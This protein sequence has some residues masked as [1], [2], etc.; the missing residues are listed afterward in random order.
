MAV[1]VLGI[2]SSPRRDGNSD[3]LLKEVL[4]GAEGAGAQVEY[5]SLRGVQMSPCVE[6]NACYETGR[7]RIED[8]FQDILGRILGC[9]RL[10]FATPIFF[11]AVCA[12]G[13]ILIDR[14]QCQWARKYVLKKPLFEPPRAGRRGWCVAVGGSRSTKMFECIRLTMKYFFDVLEMDYAGDLTVNRVDAK[15]EIL[16][17]PD[18]LQQ[19]FELG[20]QVG[21]P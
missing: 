15:G 5:L 7:C 16:K 19:A 14:H 17:H 11:M 20:R 10:V 12:S 3:L 9:D 21:A 2:S 1:R 6:C 4:R 8:A 13:K 18:V